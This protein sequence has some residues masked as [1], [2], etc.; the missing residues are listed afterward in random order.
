MQL[1]CLWQG[2]FILF[3]ENC[4]SRCNTVYIFDC[5]PIKHFK[6]LKNW[7]DSICKSQSFFVIFDIILFNNEDTQKML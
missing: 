3:M 2:K 6:P 1:L 4:I 7:I 5:F